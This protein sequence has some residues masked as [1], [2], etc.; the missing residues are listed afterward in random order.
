VSP[1]KDSCVS[2]PYCPSTLCVQHWAWSPVCLHP[3]CKAQHPAGHSVLWKLRWGAIAVMRVLFQPLANSPGKA[4]EVSEPGPDL[5][6]VCHW[7]CGFQERQGSMAPCCDRWVSTAGSCLCSSWN[8][9]WPWAARWCPRAL[10]PQPPWAT[11]FSA[12]WEGSWVHCVLC[13]PG[14]S[15]ETTF[16]NPAPWVSSYQESGFPIA[17][18][19]KG[20]WEHLAQAELWAIG[21]MDELLSL[22]NSKFLLCSETLELSRPQKWKA[23]WLFIVTIAICLVLCWHPGPLI[24]LC[25]LQTDY[26][27]LRKEILPCKIHKKMPLAGTTSLV[28][29]AIE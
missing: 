6:E 23:L 19:G 27:C 3:Q 10:C 2:S 9:K 12:H 5:S 26:H 16:C 18:R 17:V 28:S 22:N 13:P 20:W 7:E 4:M 25:E 1:W 11:S 15:E 21:R 14:D 8:Q 29:D 24:Y